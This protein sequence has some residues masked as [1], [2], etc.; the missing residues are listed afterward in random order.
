L[1]D[2]LGNPL[3][4]VLTGGQV[5][6]ITQGPTLIRGRASDYVIGDKSYDADDY[7]E[8]IEAQGALAVIPPRANRKALRWYDSE[9][10]KERH[11][12]ECFVNKI[13]QFRHIFS[14]FD[15][16]ARRYLGFLHFVAA[17]IWLR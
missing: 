2:A 11:A 5:N 14:R 7:I 1:V 12:V 16:L 17:L 15:K 13:K 6:D 3:E 9:L 10:Y 8:L 4:F